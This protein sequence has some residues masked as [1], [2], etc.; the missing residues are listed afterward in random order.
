[1]DNISEARTEIES[2]VAAPPNHSS[3]VATSI[4]QEP[5]FDGGDRHH[6]YG[7]DDDNG[8]VNV[9]N[10][11]SYANR[12]SV[13]GGVRLSEESWL[14]CFLQGFNERKVGFSMEEESEKIES[15]NEEVNEKLH[16]IKLHR[17]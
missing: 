3:M 6:S 10:S 15:E 13:V 17:R 12:C 8:D 14:N 5:I 1:M 7:G 11:N 16:P 4:S 2:I 9:S